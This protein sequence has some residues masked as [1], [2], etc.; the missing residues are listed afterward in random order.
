MFYQGKKYIL[1][2]DLRLPG[3]FSDLLPELYLVNSGQMEIFAVHPQ[4]IC[5]QTKIFLE[6]WPETNKWQSFFYHYKLTGEYNICCYLA[7]IIKNEYISKYPERINCVLNAAGYSPGRY[8]EIVFISRLKDIQKKLFAEKRIPVKILRLLDNVPE[9]ELHRIGQFILTREINTNTA[10]EIIFLWLDLDSH[11]R[12]KLYREAQGILD[13]L[14]VSSRN[15][16]GD[17]FRAALHKIR[18]PEHARLKLEMET[19]K[20]QVKGTMEINYDSFFEENSIHVCAK[21]SRA[22]EVRH[23]VESLNETNIRILENMI[24]VINKY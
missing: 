11:Q 2:D 15:N 3:N 1:K 5:S 22:D 21:L 20:K 4:A 18:F 17:Q 16:M 23:F 7:K 14:S 10:R 13:N 9:E 12:E 6:Q 19:L 8:D 24:N